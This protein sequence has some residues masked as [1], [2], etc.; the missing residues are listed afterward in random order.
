MKKKVIK[1][2][3]IIFGIIFILSIIQSL[4]LSNL[5]TKL[6]ID[7]HNDVPYVQNDFISREYYYR[8]AQGVM[9]NGETRETLKEIKTDFY[10]IGFTYTLVF[11]N[12][13]HYSGDYYQ[14]FDGMTDN[15]EKIRFGAIAS[16]Y[17][18]LEFVNFHWKVV[19]VWEDP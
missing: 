11:L 1:I 7:K 8:L 13:A 5:I 2:L 4:Y 14:K 12:K 17:V 18:D 10:E 15:G 6:R 3:L 16:T 9:D 19:K